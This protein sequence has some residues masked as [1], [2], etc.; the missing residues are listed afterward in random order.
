MYDP[1]VAKVISPRPGALTSDTA[2]LEQVVPVR[3]FPVIAVLRSACRVRASGP[4]KIVIVVVADVVLQLAVYEILTNPIKPVS[5]VYVIDV[6]TAPASTMTAESPAGPPDTSTL[7]TV[8]FDARQVSFAV[9]FT[10]T[11]V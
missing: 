3:T 8:Q 7:V 5:G 6:S 9:T 11:G 1:S 10:V 4:T 2:Q